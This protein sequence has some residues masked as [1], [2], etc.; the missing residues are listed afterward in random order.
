MKQ[1]DIF[2]MEQDISSQGMEISLKKNKLFPKI[3]P[4]HLH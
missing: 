1:S 3:I 2:K 4:H